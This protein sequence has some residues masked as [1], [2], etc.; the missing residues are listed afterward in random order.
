MLAAVVRTL[1]P[2]IVAQGIATEDE[3]GLASFE[4]RLRQQV[5]AAHA[6]VLVPTV[7]GAWGRRP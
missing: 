6:V 2:Q 1:A 3:L 5:A 4:E 7:V